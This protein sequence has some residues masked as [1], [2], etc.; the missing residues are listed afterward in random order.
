[1]SPNP[2]W[3]AMPAHSDAQPLVVAVVDPTPVS[4][5]GACRW[6]KASGI[7]VVDDVPTTNAL[8]QD[9]ILRGV[10][11]TEQDTRVVVVLDPAALEEAAAAID[12]LHAMSEQVRVLAFSSNSLHEEVGRL[13]SAGVDGFLSKT[14]ESEELIRAV[15]DVAG[16]RHSM[17]AVATATMLSTFKR[18]APAPAVAAPVLSPREVEV[19]NLAAA[20][21]SNAEIAS[22]LVIGVET[23]KTHLSRAFGKLCVSNRTAAVSKATAMGLIS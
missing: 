11:G 6:L 17:D 13:L 4:R 9:W 16:G 3:D 10:P 8:V 12:A 20:G 1:M 19:L 7:Q 18:A 21:A 15:R 5:E 22:A 14:A 2:M 23:V